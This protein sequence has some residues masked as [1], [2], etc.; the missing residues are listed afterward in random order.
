MKNYPVK[1]LCVPGVCEHIVKQKFNTRKRAEGSSNRT[2][3]NDPLSSVG[4]AIFIWLISDQVDAV[5]VANYAV[6]IS[7]VNAIF[8]YKF[9]TLWRGLRICANEYRERNVWFY[10]KACR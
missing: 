9:D 7:H 4:Y 8:V 5:T 10:P 1:Q 2:Q 6:A 3:K